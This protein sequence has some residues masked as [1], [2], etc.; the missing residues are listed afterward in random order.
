MKRAQPEPGAELTAAEAE[1]VL[2]QKLEEEKES[3]RDALWQLANFYGITEQYK[4]AL[5][6]LRKLV[7]LVPDVEAKADYVLKMGQFMESARDY[8]AAVRYYRKALAL[9]PTGHFCQVLHQ[10]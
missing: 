5:V 2:L 7:A 1:R 4:K 10:Q 6:Y 3:P 9:K 8:P